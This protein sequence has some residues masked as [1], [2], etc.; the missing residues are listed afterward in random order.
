MCMD[1][2][3]FLRSMPKDFYLIK[4]DVLADK[5]KNQEWLKQAY[6]L[7]LR[8]P[9]EHAQNGLPGSKQCL[10]KHLPDRFQELFPDRER[11]LVVYCNGGV[12]SIYAVMFLVMQ[13]YKEARS[14]A[15]GYKK[16]LGG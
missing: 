2:K 13:G 7:D 6:F 1:A 8:Q 16:F 10:L 14:L 12:Q 11:P 9:E 15:G 5:I 3:Q 4:A